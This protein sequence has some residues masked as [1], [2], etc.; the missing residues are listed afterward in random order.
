MEQYFEWHEMIEGRKF[1]LAKT[2]LIRQAR[3]YWGDVERS[4]RYQGKISIATWRDMKIWLREEYVPASY[5]QR[6]L[7]QWQ[8][9]TQGTKSVSEYI[10]KFSEFVMR[11]SVGE[12]EMVTI[13][14]FRSGLRLDLAIELSLRKVT[15]LEHAY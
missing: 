1:R 14:R 15:S 5:H 13:S 3:L 9:L 11:C 10:A 6:L 4:V 8:R 7:D 12:P 2:K